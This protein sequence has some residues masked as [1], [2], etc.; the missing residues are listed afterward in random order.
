MNKRRSKKPSERCNSRRADIGTPSKCSDKP[1]NRQSS[2]GVNT[3]VLVPEALLHPSSAR[4][5]ASQ[6][7]IAK[8][9]GVADSTLGRLVA[10]GEIRR[11]G[12]MLDL[13]DALEA[14]RTRPK[15]G[16][17]PQQQSEQPVLEGRTP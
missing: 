8:A 2:Q 15:P 16:R 7:A 6:R 1:K 13:Q 11:I 10:T 4:M 3:S 5:V 12:Q 14:I 9:C 17:P